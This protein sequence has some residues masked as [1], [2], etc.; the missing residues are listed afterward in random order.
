MISK[1]DFHTIAPALIY[2]ESK[3][4]CNKQ[5][6][7]INKN[8]IQRASL[9]STSVTNAESKKNIIKIYWFKCLI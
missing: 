8:L 9:N 2:M 1:F 7:E 4:I 6:A 5:M 3:S